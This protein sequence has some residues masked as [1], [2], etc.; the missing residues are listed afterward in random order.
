MGNI[1]KS[2]WF[3]TGIVVLLSAVGHVGAG[4]DVTVAEE[5]A[6]MQKMCAD[7]AEARA[8]RHENQA[9]YHRLG[10]YDRIHSF[11]REVVRLHKE[12]DAIKGMFEY[13]DG[14]ALAKHV[15]DFVAS[16]TGG[17]ETYSGRDMPSSHAHLKLTDKDFLAAVGDI[18][19]AM[20]TMGYGQE[21]EDEIVCI[22]VSL[23][24]QVVLR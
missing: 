19:T 16:G 15:A 24:D 12:N 6:A 14:E 8:Q 21:E 4:D 13:V 17:P 22:V 10:D 5:M 11:T 3:A 2:K 20:Q 9:L 7:T 1:L 23:K 18:V